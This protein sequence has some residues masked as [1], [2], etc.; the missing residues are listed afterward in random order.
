MFS[1]LHTNDSLQAITRLCDMGVPLYQI[2]ASL[3]GVIAPAL[4]AA[5]VPQCKQLESPA[6]ARLQALA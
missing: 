1:T 4:A 3:N 2:M 6:P 5:P